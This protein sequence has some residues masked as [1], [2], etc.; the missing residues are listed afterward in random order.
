MMK[1]NLTRLLCAILAL[2]M[3]GTAAMAEVASD[4]FRQAMTEAVGQYGDFHTWS[5]EK[6]AD[7]YN[8]HVYHGIGTRR[9]VPCN[10]V[11]QK[12]AV[13]DIAKAYMLTMVGVSEE[14]LSGYVIDVDYWIECQMEEDAE[15]EMYSVAFLTQ[16]AP[17]TFRNE[18]QISISPYSGEV[19]QCFDRDAEA[20]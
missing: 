9:G 15:H 20:E 8:M 17:H 14:K 19:I 5:F 7:F 10:H 18:Y 16:I 6:K 2:M 13:I 11:L 12:D 4:D 1:H 3:L